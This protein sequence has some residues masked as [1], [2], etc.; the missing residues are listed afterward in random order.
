MKQLMK[1]FSKDE[2]SKMLEQHQLWLDSRGY[3]GKRFKFYL[4]RI[5][6]NYI[7]LASS[8]LQHACL[9]NCHL[10][11]ANFSDTNLSK[12]DMSNATLIGYNFQNA[13]LSHV[14][15]YGANLRGTK[16]D[17]G[18]LEC[19][20]LAY[21]QWLSTDIPWYLQHPDY[22]EWADTIEILDG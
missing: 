15:L 17:S 22:A 14:S 7:Q 16:F 8:N 11:C 10:L 20:T 2:L 1:Q 18:I 19:Y 3:K 4:P 6:L 9:A 5:D 12:S 21:T 13:D